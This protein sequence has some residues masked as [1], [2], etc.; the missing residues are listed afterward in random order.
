MSE[1]FWGFLVAV[2]ALVIIIVPMTQCQ[3]ED[4]RNVEYNKC[5]ERATYQ[6]IDACRYIMGHTKDDN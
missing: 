1:D 6:D 2:S 3:Q 4:N 5:L